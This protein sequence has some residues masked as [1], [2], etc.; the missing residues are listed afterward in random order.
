MGNNSKRR[1][2]SGRRRKFTFSNSNSVSLSL[3]LVETCAATPV[4]SP[5]LTLSASNSRILLACRRNR[6]SWVSRARQRFCQ[7]TLARVSTLSS[8]MTG[9]TSSLFQGA[10]GASTQRG[11]RISKDVKRRAEKTGLGDASHCSP[12]VPP[13]LAQCVPFSHKL[14]EQTQELIVTAIKKIKKK[15]RASFVFH[16]ITYLTNMYPFNKHLYARHCSRHWKC[17]GK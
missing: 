16:L 1:R 17:K 3:A 5:G 7:S 4:S 9:A 6:K 2:R 15:K 14:A 13:P 12:S 11:E 8:A 10:L